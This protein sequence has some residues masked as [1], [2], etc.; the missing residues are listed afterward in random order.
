MTELLN[1]AAFYACSA[2]L[3]TGFL[4][5]M[6]RRAGRLSAPGYM[7]MYVYRLHPLVLFNPWLM[8]AVFDAMSS[9]YGREVNVWSPATAVSGPAI[10]L[11]LAMACVGLLSSPL[12]RYLFWP[13]VEPSLEPLWS[14]PA[15]SK[16]PVAPLGPP[17]PA[18]R[19]D[20]C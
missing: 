11:V 5:A 8:K 15:E 9:L 3:I 13:L 7:S 18:V 1:R 14:K 2:P 20:T 17:A 16:Q 6:P 10:M 4:C 19:V 12:A